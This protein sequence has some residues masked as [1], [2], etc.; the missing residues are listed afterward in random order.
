[1]DEHAFRLTRFEQVFGGGGAEKDAPFAQGLFG[2]LAVHGYGVHT[3]K[4]PFDSGNARHQQAFPLFGQSVFRTFVHIN[5]APAFG[6]ERQPL[7][8]CPQTFGTG[9][10]KRAVRLMF[11]G[12]GQ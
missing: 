12:F 7:L 1:M 5:A 3:G 10:E 8:L 9:D 11:G 4:M 2:C 6:I